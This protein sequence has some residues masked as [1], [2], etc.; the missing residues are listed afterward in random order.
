MKTLKTTVI[1]DAFTEAASKAFDYTFTGESIF[2]LPEFTP[3]EGDWGILLIVGPSGSG[4]SSLLREHFG[5]PT[6]LE[7]D[8]NKAVISHF[9]TP[10]EA[11]AR[12]SSVGFNSIPAWCRPRHVLS[13]GEGHRVDLARSLKDGAVIDEFTSVVNREAARSTAVGVRRLVDKFG[14][15]RVVLATCHYD[16]IE[17]LQ[18]DWVFDTATGVLT[19]RGALRPR[20]SVE[21]EIVPAQT[22]AVWPIFAPHHYLT[23]DCNSAAYSWVAL[24]DGVLVGFAASIAQPGFVRNAWRGHRTVVLPDYQGLGIGVRLSDAIAQ[25]HVEAGKRYFSKTAHPR[26]GEYRNRSPLWTPTAK[27]GMS[28]AD[29]MS[30]ADAR[31]KDKKFSAALKAIHA[32]RVC[33]SHEYIGN[34][35]DKPPAA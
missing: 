6:R 25:L 17:W 31:R 24:W 29:Y 7:W 16:I 22:K 21:L 33:Y 32:G 35:L 18:P 23:E 28:R 19:P 2:R 27:N 4:K 10:D 30:R 14:M 9:A 20:P 15:K 1:P 11:I 8:G 26:M 12:M 5:E 13:N 34:K 3:P